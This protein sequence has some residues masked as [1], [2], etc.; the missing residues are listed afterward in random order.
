MS[1]SALMVSLHNTNFAKSMK[2]F[3]S[4]SLDDDDEKVSSSVFF[5]KFKREER[6][7][8]QM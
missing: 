7:F 5:Y 6:K 1:R 4:V 3:I 2:Y 8:L